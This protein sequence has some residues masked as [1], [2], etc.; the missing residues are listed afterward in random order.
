LIVDFAHVVNLINKYLLNVIKTHPIGIGVL[1]DVIER[2]ME[3]DV[4][5]LVGASAGMK[6]G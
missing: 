2:D 1:E 5:H 4:Q 3:L 6:L